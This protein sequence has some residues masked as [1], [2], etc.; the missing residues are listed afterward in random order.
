VC[1]EVGGVSVGE[2]EG[3]GMAI[4]GIRKIMHAVVEREG[5]SWERSIPLKDYKNG[6]H[7]LKGEQ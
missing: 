2:W 4:N 3:D 6:K 1:E 7:F 5:S